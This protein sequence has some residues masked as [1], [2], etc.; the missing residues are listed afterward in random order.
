MPHFNIFIPRGI[1][2]HAGRRGWQDDESRLRAG[3]SLLSMSLLPMEKPLPI[4]P[5]VPKVPDGME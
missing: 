2:G 3:L 4:D 5:T 1:P